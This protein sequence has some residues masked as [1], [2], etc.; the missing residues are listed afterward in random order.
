[1]AGSPSDL[2]FLRGDPKRITLAS[3]E[4]FRVFMPLNHIGR[5]CPVRTEVHGVV[6]PPGGRVALGWAAANRDESVFADADQIRLDRKPNPHL[7]FGFG[8]HLCLG[9]PHA[10]LLMRTLLRKCVEMVRS[11]EIVCS[12]A[13]IEQEVSYQRRIG[14]DSLR[15]RFEPLE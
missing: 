2:E 5:V 7:S 12:Q 11:M 8:E 9:A 4:F 15:I 3:E 13:H 6:V 1:L 14:Y 10:R